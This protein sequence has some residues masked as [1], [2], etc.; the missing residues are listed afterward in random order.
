MWI[1]VALLLLALLLAASA[2]ALPIWQK[3]N[4]AMTLTNLS[5]TA[6]EA[7]MQTQSLRDQMEALATEYK[8]PIEQKNALPSTF[9]L[10]NQLSKLL[11]DD[12]YVSNLEVTGKDVQIQGE[13]GSS[14]KLIELMEGSGFLTEA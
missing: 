7:A 12:T 6:K 4:T 1:N 2:L 14:S 10:V 5:L 13:T 8:F 3:R 9:L 11:P